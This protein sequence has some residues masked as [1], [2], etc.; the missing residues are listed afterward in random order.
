MTVKHTKVG[1]WDL[2]VEDDDIVPI[3]P[4]ISLQPYIQSAPYVLR[5]TK[6]LLSIPK[7]RFLLAA[8]VLIELVAALLPALTLY[9]SGQMLSIVQVALD[10][11]TVDTRLLVSVAFGAFA[12]SFTGLIL[13]H[14]KARIA[15]PLR[16]CIKQHYSVHIFHAVSRLDVPTF[17][18]P[19][20]QRH[21]KQALPYHAQSGTAFQAVT[22]TLH[23]L[24]TAIQLVSESSV[25][26]N[27]LKDQPDG[28]LLAFLS[29]AYGAV[30]WTRNNKFFA[31]S[32]VWA[33]ST[34]DRDF[35]RSEGLKQ[36]ISDPIHR[37]E[38]VAGGIAPFLLAEYRQALARI[39]DYPDNFF[40]A[41]SRHKARTIPLGLFFQEIFRA[42]PEI[43]FTLRA[44]R[45]PLSIPLSL[46][47]LQLVTRTTTSMSQTL[48][49]LKMETESVI[50]TLI[51]VRQF[52][53][54]A[55]ISNR[56]KV[57]NKEKSVKDSSDPDDPLLGIPF[58]EDQQS[59]ELGINVE[60][61]QVS[62]KY[63][64][65]D[66]YALQNTS[67]KIDRGQLC[68]I[69][70][71][72]G[73]GKSTILKLIAR[74][75]D[76]LEGE[77]RINGQDIKT[78][79]LA[80]LRKAMT[81]L[82]QD[83]TLFPLNIQDNIS[84]GDPLHASDFSKV[85]KAAELGGADSFIERLPDKYE[86]YLE[87]PVRDQF[88][89]LPEGTTT[90][91]GRTIDFQAVKDAAGISNSPLGLSGGQMQRIALSRT[92]MR[93]VVSH[94]GPGLLL[95]DEPSASLDPTAEHDLFERLRQLRGSKTMIFSSHRFGNLTRHADL[96]LY[97][98]DS[99]VVEKGTH[100]QLL[101]QQGEYA[102]IWMLQA[103]A[104]I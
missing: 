34:N 27:L 9:Y 38:I 33:A 20:V 52:Y 37:Q 40:D 84:L 79:R 87:K 15:H 62:F 6:D 30:G 92:F 101:R 24:A 7:C 80:D 59:L 71:A 41:I 83:Y 63:P 85:Q 29:F 57:V 12:S 18:D 36:T 21:M 69:V 60:F 65:S 2:Y 91:S 93:S 31:S 44:V 10:H 89:S 55:N 97:M 61:Y 75:Y 45:Q 74:L 64:G 54:L 47:S 81:V 28:L 19:A 76:P 35:L 58:P 49:S 13:R 88:S 42:L 104:F 17:N 72:N 4:T 68:V 94:G 16:S 100:D 50:D 1:L 56:V 66:T 3:W 67:F 99:A 25:L 26:I 98:N 22:T 23:V 48:F 73:S 70:G 8:W 39:S 90:V 43:V 103:R 14:I 32:S 78:L 46:A 5:M 95:F 51:A 82:F 11:R 86:T 102:R 77:I 53:E 96:I